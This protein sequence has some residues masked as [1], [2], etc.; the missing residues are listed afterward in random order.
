MTELGACPFSGHG[1]A[2]MPVAGRGPSPRDWWPQQINLGILRQHC[3]AS[4]PLGSDF[5]YAEAFSQLDYHGLK[6]DLIAL[7]TDSQDLSLIHI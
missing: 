4:N 5:N 2:A 1:S 7:M 6:R 3:P